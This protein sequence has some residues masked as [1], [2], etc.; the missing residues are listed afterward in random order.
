MTVPLR[1]EEQQHV[2]SEF[3]KELWVFF[4]CLLLNGS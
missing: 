3:K 4:V 1:L 2:T